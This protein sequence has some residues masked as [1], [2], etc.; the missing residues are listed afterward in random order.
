MNVIF[1]FETWVMAV[2]MDHHEEIMN[3]YEAVAEVKDNFLYKCV[4]RPV[5]T[6]NQYFV[7]CNHLN[8]GLL[9]ENDEKRERFLI[10]LNNKFAGKDWDMES[11]Y[12]F[13]QAMSAA[14]LRL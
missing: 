10:Y 6:G 4:C 11:W 5:K 3:L 14:D 13:Q 9:L 12:F 7:T 2:D 8:F 1:D